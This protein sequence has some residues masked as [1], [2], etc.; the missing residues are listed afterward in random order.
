[1]GE[2][3]PGCCCFN[4]RVACRMHPY[5]NSIIL[6]LNSVSTAVWRA[7]CIC[8]CGTGTHMIIKVSTAVWRAGCIAGVTKFPATHFEFQPP[9]GVQD[10][11][12]CSMFPGSDCLFQP[13]CG[14]QDASVCSMFPGS[15]CLF[16]PPC[17]VQDASSHR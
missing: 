17:S 8:F 14:V 6:K 4:R 9:C 16:Q 10:A 5:G 13:P 1:M 7:G 2:R 3:N 11:S 15:D 12:V